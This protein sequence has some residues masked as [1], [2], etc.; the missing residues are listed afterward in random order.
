MHVDALDLDIRL[1]AG[2][3]LRSE[4]STKFTPEDVVS[5]LNHAGFVVEDTWEEPGEFL[6]LLARPHC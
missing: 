6:L 4:I 2:E 1:D 3:E 5:D